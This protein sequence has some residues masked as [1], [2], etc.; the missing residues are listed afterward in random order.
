M[1]DRDVRKG[2]KRGAAGR[3]AREGKTAER[4]PKRAARR[5]GLRYVNDGEPGLCRVP[6]GE[7]F[8]FVGPSGEAVRDRAT[9]GRIAALAIPPAY[10]DV[11]ICADAHGH[12]QA[13]GRDAKGRK[14]YRYHPDWSA[15]RGETKYA[16][17]RTFGE[18]LPA[19]RRRLDADLGARALSREKVL[20][21]IVTLLDRTHLR[22][23]NREYAKNNRTYGLTTLLDRHATVDGA[24]ITFRFKGKHGKLNAVTLRD[25][26]L[27]RAVHRC[28]DVPGQS[29]FQYETDAG[30]HDVTSTDVNAYLREVTGEAFTAKDF[31][32]WGGTVAGARYL[33]ALEEEDAS[34]AARKRS[35]NAMVEAVAA[36]LGNTKAVSRKHYIHPRLFELYETGDF[37]GTWVR[38]ADGPHPPELDADEAALLRFLES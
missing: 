5:T 19:L 38:C 10:T 6:K 28:R 7:G 36:D 31:R 12:L 15:A 2:P 21:L 35:L 30:P 20:A 3:K 18:A 17:M 34:D 25:A 4:D 11:W 24:R 13:T 29:L 9:L 23:G 14:Q 37:A 26:R 27:A 33:A 1:G 16:R 22:V 32:T 8:R